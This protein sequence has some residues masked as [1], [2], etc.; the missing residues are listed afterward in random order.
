MSDRSKPSRS[1]AAAPQPASSR[2]ASR[3]TEIARN[4]FM[5]S[6]RGEYSTRSP[7]GNARRRG[8]TEILQRRVPVA[9]AAVA[10]DGPSLFRGAGIYSQV[11]MTRHDLLATA[12]FGLESLV[13]DE[14]SGLGIEQRTVENG[15]VRFSGARGRHRPVQCAPAHGRPHLRRARGVP[16][17]R[18]RC[19]LR[20]G[21]RDRLAEPSRPAMPRS[22][23]TPGR[24]RRA[25]R[26]SPPSSRSPRRRSWRRSRAAGRVHGSRRRGRAWTRRSGCR[27]TVPR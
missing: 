5:V 15:H 9:S 14:L 19:P 25:S 13:A 27:R 22:R 3:N 2:P 11:N 12:S 24:R 26:P 10:P 1:R 17:A 23:S 20:G 16:R 6:S 18:L 7:R 21:A 4:P 8:L